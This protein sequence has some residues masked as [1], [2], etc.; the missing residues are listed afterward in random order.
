MKYFFTVMF[1]C[2]VLIY[3]D[4]RM[5]D[6]VGGVIRNEVADYQ[7]RLPQTPLDFNGARRQGCA[8]EKVYLIYSFQTCFFLSGSKNEGDGVFRYIYHQPQMAIFSLLFPGNDSQYFSETY[9]GEELAAIY[10][11]QFVE[12]NKSDLNTN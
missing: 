10:Q 11:G 2:A 12:T 7:K 3:A 8:I 5:A 4:F 6:Y 1:L 9:F